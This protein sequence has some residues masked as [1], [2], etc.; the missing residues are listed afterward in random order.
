MNTP[1]KAVHEADAIKGQLI[2]VGCFLSAL[3]RTLPPETVRTLMRE[4]DVELAEA[5]TALTFSPDFSDEVITGLDD[6]VRTW[7]SIRE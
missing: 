2:G 4:F 3:V 1:D 7:D 5:K 6:Y